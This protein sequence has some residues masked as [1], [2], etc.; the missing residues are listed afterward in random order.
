MVTTFHGNK[1]VTYFDVL[2]SVTNSAVL[3]F[4]ILNNHTKRNQYCKLNSSLLNILILNFARGNKCKIY[5]KVWNT[6]KI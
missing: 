1:N 2:E 5:V 4:V 6:R 3:V